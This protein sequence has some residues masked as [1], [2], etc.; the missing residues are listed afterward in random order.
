MSKNA[1]IPKIAQ[2]LNLLICFVF[3]NNKPC[4]KF[5]L[6]D[7]R[8]RANIKTPIKSSLLKVFASEADPAW[9]NTQLLLL[10]K[11]IVKKAMKY[12]HLFCFTFSFNVYLL[13]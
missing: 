2:I 6:I 3:V 5:V 12:D 10:N 11:P 9:T 7:I 4:A 8:L 1:K 13:G